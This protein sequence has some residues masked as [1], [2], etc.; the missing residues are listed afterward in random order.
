M[1]RVVNTNSTGKVRNQM[2][3]TAA[4]MLR[5]LSQK[6]AL[7]DEARDMTALVVYCLRAVEEG[8]EASAEVWESR[9]YWLKADQLRDR[10]GWTGHAAARL[11]QMIRDDAWETLPAIMAS[12]AEHFADIRI[13]KMTRSAEAWTG[14]YDRLIDELNSRR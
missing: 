7:D 12:L 14:A 6:Q 4:E 8:I 2:M 3:R 11:E 5:H 13:T 1:G 9:D 10:W